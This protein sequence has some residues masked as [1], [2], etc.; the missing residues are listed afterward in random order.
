[1]LYPSWLPVQSFDFMIECV[2]YILQWSHWLFCIARN[3]VPF[4]TCLHGQLNCI[5]EILLRNL[6]I[7]AIESHWSTQC[8]SENIE[9]P[10]ATPPYLL[11]LLNL[12][13]GYLDSICNWYFSPE[14]RGHIVFCFMK[15]FHFLCINLMCTSA[16]FYPHLQF[17][18]TSWSQLK[19]K[20]SFIFLSSFTLKKSQAP[21]SCDMT[22]DMQWWGCSV[23]NVALVY[24]ILLLVCFTSSDLIYE[25]WQQLARRINTLFCL[26]VCCFLCGSRSISP[27]CYSNNL[28]GLLRYIIHVRSS[29]SFWFIVVLNEFLV[30]QQ[31]VPICRHCFRHCLI[32]IFDHYFLIIY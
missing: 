5:I 21:W 24:M 27:R 8:H 2:G 23:N 9:E 15:Y 3:V 19:C 4:R 6:S 18:F 17:V 30:Q 1:M 7:L 31:L 32:H 28:C 29:N 12:L 22:K 14:L 25:L 11:K 13:F 16:S 26:R 20:V 10:K